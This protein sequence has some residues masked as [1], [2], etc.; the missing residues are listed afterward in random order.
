MA[1]RHV[2][3]GNDLSPLI[4]SIS[5]QLKHSID[6]QSPN[7]LRCVKELAEASIFKL[8]QGIFPLGNLTPTRLSPAELSR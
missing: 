4:C 7:D 6:D 1:K 5:L 2:V 8:L 3:L